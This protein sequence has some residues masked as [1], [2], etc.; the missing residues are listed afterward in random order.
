MPLPVEDEAAWG[1]LRLDVELL[2][3]RLLR[4]PLVL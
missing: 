3:P 1:G 2:R 4:Q